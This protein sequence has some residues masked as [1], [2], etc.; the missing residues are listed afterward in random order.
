MV[1]GL[2]YRLQSGFR[3]NEVATPHTL[4]FQVGR[5]PIQERL[6]PELCVLRLQYPMSFI[7]ENHEF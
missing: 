5:Q 4:L 3:T 1:R 6:V 2:P 7:R